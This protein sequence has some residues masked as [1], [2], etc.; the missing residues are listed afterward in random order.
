ME[1]Q[2][3]RYQIHSASHNFSVSIEEHGAYNLGAE[4]VIFRPSRPLNGQNFFISTNG[5]AFFADNGNLL[6]LK[7]AALVVILDLAN[8]RVFHMEPPRP[9]LLGRVWVEKNLLHADLYQHTDLNASRQI[10]PIPL[11]TLADRL[12][13]GWGRAADGLFPTANLVFV[14][15]YKQHN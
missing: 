10:D 6:V 2:L 13:K 1:S 3:L 8:D 12:T 4:N 9:W 11:V 15:R 7:D 5:R 14:R